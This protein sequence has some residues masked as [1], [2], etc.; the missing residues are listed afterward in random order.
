MQSTI[1]LTKQGQIQQ[2]NGKIKPSE[3]HIDYIPGF[4]EHPV[5]KIR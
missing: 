3:V 1:N 4:D 2:N 5:I